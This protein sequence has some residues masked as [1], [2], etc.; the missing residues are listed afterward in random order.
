MKEISFYVGDYAELNLKSAAFCY[1]WY[2]PEGAE[3]EEDCYWAFVSSGVTG[4]S[5]F[6]MPS[7]EL[8]ELVE[9]GLDTFDTSGCMIVGLGVVIKKLQEEIAGL[10]AIC[11]NVPDGCTPADARVLRKANH[12]LIDRV[13][14]LENAAKKLIY[15]VQLGGNP[16]IEID[17]IYELKQLLSD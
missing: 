11:K 6:V 3:T 17:A 9:G 2:E 4:I 1:G 8:A 14:A 5:D 10:E 7:G 15:A 13:F 16:E 12:D